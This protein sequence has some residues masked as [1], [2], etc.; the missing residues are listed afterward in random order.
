MARQ[1]QNNS[2]G[3]PVLP[4]QHS[5]TCTFA[6]YEEFPNIPRNA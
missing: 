1:G 6:Q 5:E 3:Y 2:G 4:L